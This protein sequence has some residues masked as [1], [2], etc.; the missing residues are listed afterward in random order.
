MST[1]G[2]LGREVTTL[3]Y[4]RVISFSSRYRAPSNCRCIDCCLCLKTQRTEVTTLV[5]TR[6]ISFKMWLSGSESLSLY[7][8][9]CLAE[10]PED[11]KDDPRRMSLDPLR[12]IPASFSSLLEAEDPRHPVHSQNSST[13]ISSTTRSGTVT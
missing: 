8:L 9:L 7:R 5:Y 10:D 2:P 4:K 6:V 13:K 3:V 12:W 1:A 11:V